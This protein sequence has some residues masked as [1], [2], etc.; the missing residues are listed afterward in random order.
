MACLKMRSW[1]QQQQQ[2]SMNE[3]GLDSNDAQVCDVSNLAAAPVFWLG[4]P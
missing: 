1:K 2:Q 3:S 4:L